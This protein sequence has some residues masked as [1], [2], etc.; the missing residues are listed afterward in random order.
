M[1]LLEEMEKHIS[2]FYQALERAGRIISAVRDPDT[3]PLTQH[4]QKWQVRLHKKAQ[5]FESKLQIVTM[6]NSH[7]CFTV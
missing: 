2:A 4:K 5:N 3:Q 6:Q 7:V 1:P